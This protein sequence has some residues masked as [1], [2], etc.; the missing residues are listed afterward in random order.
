M[1]FGIASPRGGRSLIF[2]FEE[3]QRRVWMFVP[4]SLSGFQ[5][6]DSKRT[7]LQQKQDIRIGES[8]VLIV[9]HG[10]HEPVVNVAGELE[11][12]GLPECRPQP[13]KNRPARTRSICASLA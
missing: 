12:T 4:G 1:G 10:P 8:V 7:I 6:P 13:T 2:A 11:P 3:M 9:W 5:K